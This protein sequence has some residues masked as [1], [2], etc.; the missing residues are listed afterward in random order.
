MVSAALGEAV[1][2]Q[3]DDD[4]GGQ[5]GVQQQVGAGTRADRHIDVGGAGRGGT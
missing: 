1:A 3:A 5:T 2:E 4:G